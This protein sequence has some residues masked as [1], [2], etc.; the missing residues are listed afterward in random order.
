MKILLF[1]PHSPP[2]RFTSTALCTASCRENSKS[3][4]FHIQNPSRF[5]VIHPQAVH[6]WC[7]LRVFKGCIKQRS[8]MG[9]LSAFNHIARSTSA[10]SLSTCLVMS[11]CYGEF[12]MSSVLCSPDTALFILFLSLWVPPHASQ[13]YSTQSYSSPSFP[14]LISLFSTTR[15]TLPKS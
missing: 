10:V 15:V 9:Y 8:A 12:L 3:W 13:C 5:F 7:K 4:S 11:G 2:Q 1:T 14:L 6:P